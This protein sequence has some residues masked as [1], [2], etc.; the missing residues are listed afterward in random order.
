MKCD[1]CRQEIKGYAN[2]ASPIIKGV[3]CDECNRKVIAERLAR[4]GV[5]REMY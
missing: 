3:C 1:I 5:K 2:N 4:L